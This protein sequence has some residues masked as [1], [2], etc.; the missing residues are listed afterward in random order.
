MKYPS[1]TL[2]FPDLDGEVAAKTQEVLHAFMDAF[3][4]HYCR[5]IEQYHRESFRHGEISELDEEMPPF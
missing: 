2:M 5:R 3:D 4:A 1:F